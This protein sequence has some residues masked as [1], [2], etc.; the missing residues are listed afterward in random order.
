MDTIKS[1]AKPNNK[2]KLRNDPIKDFSKD[3]I[4]GNHSYCAKKYKWF[5]IDHVAPS[6][7][8]EKVR[9]DIVAHIDHSVAIIPRTNLSNSNSESD[10]ESNLDTS[11]LLIYHKTATTM[12]R[13]PAYF[14]KTIKATVSKAFPLGF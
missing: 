10:S 3:S 9:N 11:L 12:I 5:P 8:G 1:S 13:T 6:A 4:E 14:A 2:P 7:A